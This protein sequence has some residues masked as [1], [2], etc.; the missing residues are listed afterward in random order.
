[1]E[2]KDEQYILYP[3]SDYKISINSALVYATLRRHMNENKECFPSVARICELSKLSK[4]AVNAAIKEL[5]DK[6]FITRRKDG[7]RTIYKFP[8]IDKF[9]IFSYDFLDK[10]DL[11]TSE[12][13]LLILLQRYLIKSGGYGTTWYKN[14]ELQNLLDISEKTLRKYFKSLKNKGY[15]TMGKLVRKDGEQVDVKQINLMNLGQAIVFKLAEHDEKIE[16]HDERIEENSENIDIL[17]KKLNDNDKEIE[18]LKE[19][20]RLLKKQLKLKNRLEESSR[21]AEEELY[22][23]RHGEKID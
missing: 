12:K 18:K 9:E 5:T 13:G 7:N 8:E 1:M 21:L 14:V 2:N 15:L 4:N 23:I 20:I 17:N 19:E 10:E 22:R 11:S 6:E 16:E 3:N